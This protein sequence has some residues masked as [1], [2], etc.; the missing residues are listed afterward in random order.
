MQLKI[1]DHVVHPAF[2]IGHIVEIEDKQFSDEAARQYYKVARLK[3][4]MWTRVQAPEESGLRRVTAKSELDYYR[5]V[6]K[7]LPVPLNTNLQERR[8]ELVNRLK[9]GSFQAVC[10]VMRDLTAWS[11]QT[12]LDQADATTLQKTG[13]SL[14]QEWAAAADVSTSEAIKEIDSL[15][16]SS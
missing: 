7:S 5:D 13:D 3:H 8:L 9:Q 15:L 16:R 12:P 2:G 14:Y 6:L 11:L 1:G 4:T 10:E